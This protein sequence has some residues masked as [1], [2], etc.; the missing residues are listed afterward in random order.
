M[1][2]ADAR[3]G[4]CAQYAA[5]EDWLYYIVTK[6]GCSQLA[7]VGSDGH[8]ELLTHVQGTVDGIT[9]A[10]GRVCG[11]AAR[12]TRS[13]EVYSFSA[14]GEKRLTC[15]N[16]NYFA[17]HDAAPVETW[18]FMRGGTELEAFALLPEAQGIYSAYLAA[19]AAS[20]AAPL[21]ARHDTESL[22]LVLK[23]ADE[24]SHRQIALACSQ[25][26]WSEGAALTLGRQKTYDFD[27][28]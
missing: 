23:L 22:Q 20:A 12:G 18:R 25:S 13:A 24:E 8:R 3:Y 9:A 28:L 26:G 27:D 1:T 2:K 6:D 14:G 16:E 7:R 11:V 17:T 21:I 4:S 19:H 15:L 10:K 5:D